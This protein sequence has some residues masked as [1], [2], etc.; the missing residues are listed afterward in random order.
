M[1]SDNKFSQLLHPGA[2]HNWK[3][4]HFSEEGFIVAQI[5]IIALLLP[6]RDW[7]F[8]IK[9]VTLYVRSGSVRRNSSENFSSWISFKC[10]DTPLRNERFFAD[11]LKTW[12]QLH[13]SQ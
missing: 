9:I 13:P 10:I 7:S 2:R 5:Y 11:V 4:H 8:L 6:C 3:L 12:K 1:G